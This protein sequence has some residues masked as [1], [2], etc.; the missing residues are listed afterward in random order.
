MVMV[1]G[2]ATIAGAD[3]IVKQHTSSDMMGMMKM[4]VDCT[5]YVKGDKSC[6]MSKI[7][8]IGGM[9]AM[10]G[11]AGGME[12]REI[13][14]ID[15]VVKWN[16]DTKSSTYTEMTMAEID[17]M[18]GSD[19][20]YEEGG[21]GMGM[22]DEAD[23]DWTVEVTTDDN[24]VDINGFMCKKITGKASGVGIKNPDEKMELT[25]EYWYS[26]NVPGIDELNS[27]YEAIPEATGTEMTNNQKGAEAFYG[28]YGSQFDEMFQKLEQSGGYP[29]KTVILVQ[30]NQSMGGMGGDD[31]DLDDENIPSGMKDMLGGLMGKKDEPGGLKTLFSITNEV[32]SIEEKSIDDSR[33][34]IPEG[35]QKAQY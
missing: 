27:Y 12:S 28:M 33:F 13:T 20:S 6:N 35:Y 2:L 24:E 23:Y 5:E 25:F 21:P 11:D 7:K 26:Q 19:E 29:I 8:M 16:L 4:S 30:G 34:E 9:A 10:M 3:V 17:E 32:T 1:V 18:L 15:K 14:R 22:G 31:V